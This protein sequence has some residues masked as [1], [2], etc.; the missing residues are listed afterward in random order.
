MKALV[1]SDTHVRYKDEIAALRL[2]IEPYLSD[3]DIIFH[4]GDSTSMA[5]VDLFNELKTTYVVAGNM[6]D[7]QTSYYLSE[8]LFVDFAGFKVGIT[9]GWGTA[10]GIVD[11]VFEYFRGNE[12][13]AI[14]F[15]HSHQPYIGKREGILML[16]PGSPTDKRFAERNSIAILEAGE[17]LEA[18]IIE[19]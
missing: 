2:I 1:L 7:S 17:E 11:R 19:L 6:D 12:V 3:V 5:A 14:I 4:A 9:H 10:S 16:N 8:K 15:G 18:R 13:D